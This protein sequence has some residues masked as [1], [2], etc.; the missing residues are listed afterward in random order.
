MR[1]PQKKSVFNL[2]AGKEQYVIPAYQRGYDWRHDR[3]ITDFWDDIESC[4]K[5]KDRNEL[6]LGT[7]II[8][9]IEKGKDGY[10]RLEIID[11]QQRITTIFIFLIAM[12]S[13]ADNKL[14]SDEV[15]ANV[16]HDMI[17]LKKSLL[18][19]SNQIDRFLPSNK[20]QTIFRYI[21][22]RDWNQT[23]PR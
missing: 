22:R 17:A 23:F 7:A 21:A 6:F 11:G 19:K 13:Y 15:D 4:L 1:A 18:K 8:R 10:P 3:Q 14:E 2:L 16:I 9:T 12:R 5:A 20:I